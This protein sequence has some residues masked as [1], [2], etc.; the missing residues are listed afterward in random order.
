MCPNYLVQ[1]LQPVCF[2]MLVLCQGEGSEETL[3][4][5]LL[6]FFFNFSLLLFQTEKQEERRTSRAVLCSRL[7]GK[8][9]T[10]KHFWNQSAA[11][12]EGGMEKSAPRPLW[13]PVWVLL[14]G[15][16]RA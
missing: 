2:K 9:H 6:F 12:P 11:R 16:A 3:F 7:T 13:V 15:S 8:W 4:S 5:L 1:L 10:E 14:W